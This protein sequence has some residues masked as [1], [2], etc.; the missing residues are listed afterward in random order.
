MSVEEDSG[1][2][3]GRTEEPVYAQYVNGS[4][5]HILTLENARAVA[6]MA[7]AGK[8][9]DLDDGGL[10]FFDYYPGEGK[11]EFHICRI[12]KATADAWLEAIRLGLHES[13]RRVTR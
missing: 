2:G 9:G 4:R 5:T 8:T 7:L 6:S 1:T 13:R 3:E 11:R 12:D 10:R